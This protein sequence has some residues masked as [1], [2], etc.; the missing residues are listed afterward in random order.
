MVVM[1]LIG[2]LLVSCLIPNGDIVWALIG[3]GNICYF[4]I[5]IKWVA[6]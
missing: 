6:H 5:K 4:H 3:L 1:W 2:E